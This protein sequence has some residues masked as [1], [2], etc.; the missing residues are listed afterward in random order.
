MLLVQVDDC[1]ILLTR[2]NRCFLENRQ[3]M[4]CNDRSKRDVVIYCFFKALATEKTQIQH[5]R[6]V[7]FQFRLGIKLKDMLE[8]FSK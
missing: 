2:G 1:R 7:S 8:Y 4:Y 3:E 5:I 6:A